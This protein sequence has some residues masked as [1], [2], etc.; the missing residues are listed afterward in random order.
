MT[1]TPTEI[2][3]APDTRLVTSAID[4]RCGTDKVEFYQ[5]GDEWYVI[6]YYDDGDEA[7]NKLANTFVPDGWMDADQAIAKYIYCKHQH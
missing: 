4:G 7:A 1:I 5:R 2:R 6:T 3:T